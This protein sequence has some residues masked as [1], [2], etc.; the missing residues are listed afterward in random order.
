VEDPFTLKIFI[1]GRSSAAVRAI[2][3]LEEICASL[4]SGNRYLIEVVDIHTAPDHA[5]LE[6]ILATPTVIRKSP[7]PERRLIGDM[8]FRE[9]VVFGLGL[10]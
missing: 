8:S 7:P 10:E 3:N 5:E 4:A 6:R 9:Q 1:A 2:S